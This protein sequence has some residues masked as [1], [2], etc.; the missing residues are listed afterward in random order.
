MHHDRYRT[1]IQTW[2]KLAQAYQDRFMDFDLYDDTYDAFCELLP[3]NASVFEIGCGPGNITRYLLKQRPDLDIVA[4]DVAPS[5]VERARINNPGARFQVMDA[6]EI[7]RSA[8]QFDGII[9]GFCMPYLEKTAVVQLIHDCAS[10][11][12]DGGV[13]YFSVIED[14]YARSGYQA[15]S[16][17]KH[18]AYVY[19]YDAQFLQEQ[20]IGND[21]EIARLY[22]KTYLQKDTHLVG[23]CRKKPGR[24]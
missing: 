13:F 16:S 1:T 10:L 22:R 9:C 14:D 17:G 8:T 11:L 20:L 6:R 24:K 2:D 19:Y 5:M 15:D 18:K 3:E 7:G 23:I 4:T 21:F 12:H